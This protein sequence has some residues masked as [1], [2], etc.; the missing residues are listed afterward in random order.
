MPSKRIA[1]A[2]TLATLLLGDVASAQRKIFP[3]LRKSRTTNVERLANAMDRVEREIDMLGSVVVKQPDVWGEARWTRHRAEYEEQLA[4]QLSAF[5]FTVNAK[6]SEAD[7]AYLIQA[8]ALGNAFRQTTTTTTVPVETSEGVRD[9]TTSREVGPSPFANTIG[10]FSGSSR[11]TPASAATV[12]G[13]GESE[14]I[15]GV[16]IEPVLFLDQMSRYIKHL[17]QLRRVNEGD[18]TADAPGYALNLMRIPVS[19][20]P[21]TKTRKGYGA[22]VHLTLTPELGPELLPDTFRDLV[23]ND[24]VDQL[25]LPVLKLAERLM[26]SE[27]AEYRRSQPVLTA[28]GDGFA[29][30]GKPNA[31]YPVNWDRT[32]AAMRRLFGSQLD[33]PDYPKSLTEFPE[34]QRETI[35]RIRRSVRKRLQSQIDLD[36]VLA[37]MGDGAFARYMSDVDNLRRI[38]TN[39]GSLDDDAVATIQRMAPNLKR[40][41]KLGV[42]PIEVRKR[43]IAAV[44]GSSEKFDKSELRTLAD[45][46]YDPVD[47]G[48][49][50]ASA[51]PENNSVD[52]RGILSEIFTSTPAPRARLA[53][54]GFPMSEVPAVIGEPNLLLLADLVRVSSSSSTPNIMDVRRIIREQA[55][56]AFRFL[57]HRG[58]WNRCFEIARAVRELKYDGTDDSLRR[59]RDAHTTSAGVGT[60]ARGQAIRAVSWAILVESAL[61]NERLVRDIQRVENRQACRILPSHVPPFFGSDPPADARS[62]FNEYVRKRWPI[63][64]FAIDPESQDQNVSDAFARRRESQLA[65]SLAFTRGEISADTFTE[66]GRRLDYQLETVS[67]NRTVVG[68]SHGNDTFGWRMYPRVQAPP[69]QSNLKVKV[70]DLLI[71]GPSRERDLKQRQLE[72]GPRELLAVVIMPSFVP[73]CNMTIRT[74]WFDLTRPSHKRFDM[75]DSVRLGQMIQELRTC[76]SQC[77][78]EKHVNRP[79][80]LGRVLHAS[81]QLERRL[82][83]QEARI[84]VPYENSQGGF[85]LFADGTQHL[86]PEL[87]GFYGEPGIDPA[88]TT[89]LFLVGRNFNINVTEL[90]VGGKTAGAELLSRE[91]IKVTIPKD[92]KTFKKMVPNWADSKL[93]EKTFAD[94]HLATPTGVSSHLHIPV[95]PPAPKAAAKPTFSPSDVHGC[96]TFDG[97][98]AN[99]VQLSKASV[100]ITG[101][102]KDKELIMDVSLEAVSSTGVAETLKSIDA[103]K[104]TTTLKYRIPVGHVNSKGELELGESNV[105]TFIQRFFNGDQRLLSNSDVAYLNL[106]VSFKDGDTAIALE[107]PLKIITGGLNCPCPTPVATPAS[108]MNANATPW[109]RPPAVASQPRLTIP[110]TSRRQ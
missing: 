91:L 22:E 40:Y 12:V 80:D 29:Q 104:A 99:D 94:A 58:L 109:G 98:R 64:V 30:A 2:L 54:F 21:G 33:A 110:A 70:R 57:D 16:A 41:S 17:H 39:Q 105:S 68:F 7:S 106:K 83:L 90:I 69:V 82:P 9:Q 32:L 14:A 71:G 34:D 107:A 73:H 74:N 76:R 45:V 60:N 102:P 6:I 28:F 15:S 35:A 89:E 27:V 103:G 61:L 101:L 18:D 72:P 13:N 5:K 20:L 96:I 95:I 48:G 51:F 11:F 38:T 23:I 75:A 78:E 59:A 63:H 88:G 43:L 26:L 50:F 97:C 3:G 53:A 100:K 84:Q 85:Q 24:V 4:K 37:D 52:V 81:N 44:D 77:V 19:V 67:L 93:V 66:F 36:V 31:G 49:A 1:C 42:L 108:R 87:L 56:A 55:A 47:W 86:G 25:S 8:A 79:G 65:A 46:K 92:V 10:S 62:I